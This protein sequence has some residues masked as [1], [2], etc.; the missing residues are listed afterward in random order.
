MELILSGL[1]REEAISSAATLVGLSAEEVR[2]VLRTP[3]LA[4]WGAS[5]EHKAIGE[6]MKRPLGRVHTQSEPAECRAVYWFPVA[7]PIDATLCALDG[8]AARW[9]VFDFELGDL[10]R[11]TE[12]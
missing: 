6:S 4:Q 8:G 7:R 12:G 11:G 2:R 3:G 9:L 5:A 10:T 1:D